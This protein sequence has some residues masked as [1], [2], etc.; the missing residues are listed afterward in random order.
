MALAYDELV[1]FIAG[2]T[3]PSSLVRFQA[4]QATKDR[5]EELIRREKAK[6]LSPDERSELDNYL[7][8]E[9]VLRL[10]KA[11]ARTRLSDDELR[12]E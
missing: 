7:Q 10:A 1:D 4:S 12:S 2:G 11:R 5:V 3:S 9:H 8:L 6:E